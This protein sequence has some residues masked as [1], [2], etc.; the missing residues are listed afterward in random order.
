MLLSDCVWSGCLIE[1]K[2][3]KDQLIALF[4]LQRARS[5]HKISY[6]VFLP[7]HVT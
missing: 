2:D 4:A 1:I 3:L 5:L 7:Q 6:Y